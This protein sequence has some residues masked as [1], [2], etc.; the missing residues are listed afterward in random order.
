MYELKLCTYLF[1]IDVCSSV[2]LSVCEALIQDLLVNV[3]NVLDEL[4]LCTFVHQR[5]HVFQKGENFGSQY[6]LVIKV[7][8]CYD[9]NLS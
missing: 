4:K 9:I 3:Y 6:I 8:L 1:M 7:I 5:R 2:C